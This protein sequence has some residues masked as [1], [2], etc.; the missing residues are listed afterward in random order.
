MTEID[1]TLSCSALN[2]PPQKDVLRD[3]PWKRDAKSLQIYFW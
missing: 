3:I 2:F 1:N